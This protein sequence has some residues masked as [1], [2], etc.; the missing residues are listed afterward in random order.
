MVDGFPLSDAGVWIEQRRTLTAKRALLMDRDGAIIVDRGYLSDPNGVELIDGVCEILRAAEARG[1]PIA[2]VTNQSGVGRGYFGW[3]EFQSVQERMLSLLAAE[4]ISPAAVI[5]CAYHADAL[6]PY[7][8]DDSPMRKPN[9]GML[10]AA[11]RMFGADARRS[12]MI[13]DKPDD[14]VAATRA[15]L[16]AGILVG[17]DWPFAVTSGQPTAV[18]ATARIRDAVP[19]AGDWLANR[20][21]ARPQ[22]AA[23]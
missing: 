3:R 20:W 19:I 5:A 18:V 9:P 1:V 13:G 6:A 23:R 17:A 7:R 10:L 8:L 2:I 21:P 12:L 22:Q 14:V 4:G 16:Q 15:G 11:L